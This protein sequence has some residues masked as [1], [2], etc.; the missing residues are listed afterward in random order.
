MSVA[1][2]RSLIVILAV[3]LWACRN[4]LDFGGCDTYA[5]PALRL[6][7]ID[8]RTGATLPGLE[9]AR[10][11]ARDGAFADTALLVNA[12]TGGIA[13]ERPGTY[14]VTVEYPGYLLWSRTNI[15]V[16]SDRCHVRTKSITASLQRE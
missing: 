15:A 5:S 3:S 6:S 8:A 12:T 4:P 9:G 10:A 1:A 16:T 14:D 11:I 2:S 7:V 13:Y